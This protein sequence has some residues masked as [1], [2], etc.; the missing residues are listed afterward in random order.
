MEGNR[1]VIT[2]EKV[3]NDRASCNSTSTSLKRV[4][5]DEHGLSADREILREKLIAATVDAVAEGS[6]ARLAES[7]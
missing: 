3:L 2:R 5:P 4:P 6:V 1:G 7:R